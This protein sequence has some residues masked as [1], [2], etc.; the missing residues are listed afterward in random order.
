VVVVVAEVEAGTELFRRTMQRAFLR[1]W[2]Y[3]ILH[4]ACCYLASRL[5]STCLQYVVAF[6]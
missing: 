3:C 1:N 2:G 4:T 6:R 5:A